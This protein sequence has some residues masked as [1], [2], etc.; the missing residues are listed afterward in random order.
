MG[1]YLGS[2]LAVIWHTLL[3]LKAVFFG[4]RGIFAM[5]KLDNMLAPGMAAR[6]GLVVLPVSALPGPSVLSVYLVRVHYWCPI[7]ITL[8]QVQGTLIPQ[9]LAPLAPSWGPLPPVSYQ[10]S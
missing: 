9:L 4:G 7:L 10:C 6:H 1:L 2:I 8:L 5:S 3:M